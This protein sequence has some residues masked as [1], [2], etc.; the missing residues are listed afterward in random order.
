MKKYL[1]IIILFLFIVLFG[2]LIFQITLK[3]KHKNEVAENIKSIPPFN[4]QNVK[5][6]TFYQ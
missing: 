3:I 1:K 4:F 2:S 6:G 5:G